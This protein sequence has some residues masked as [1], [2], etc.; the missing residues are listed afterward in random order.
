MFKTFYK[1]SCKDVRYLQ[2][3]LQ[4]FINDML[5]VVEVVQ[6]RVQVG[7]SEVSG[8]LFA[9]EFVQATT[10]LEELQKKIGAAI[11]FGRK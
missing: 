6:R 10:T 4:V 2:H 5:K 11:Q 3:S 8:P 9:D 1:G 7:G